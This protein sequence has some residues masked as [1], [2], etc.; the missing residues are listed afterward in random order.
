[1]EC[2][3]QF[4]GHDEILPSQQYLVVTWSNE[5]RKVEVEVPVA[6][7]DIEKGAAGTKV[8]WM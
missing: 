6:L 4:A 2:R 8:R 7:W 1:V 3:T 5:S